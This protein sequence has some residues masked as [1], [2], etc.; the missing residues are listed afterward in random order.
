[1]KKHTLFLFLIGGF[2]SLQSQAQESRS[3]DSINEM[4]STFILK[5]GDN[6]VDSSGDTDPFTSFSDFD[7]MAFSDNY[8]IELEYRFSKW[9]SM[10]V[11]MGNNKWI[12]NKGNIDGVIVNTDQKYLA[13]DLDLKFYY[14]ERFD[15][16]DRNDWVELYL[17]GGLGTV[18][19][20]NTSG[21]SLNFGP[22]ANFW[23]T[24]QFRVNVNS[25]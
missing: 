13:L 24:K 3:N 17:H 20:A 8:N 23:I 18:V 22:G 12:A 10:A 16:F 11:S 21:V 9:F 15:W 7:Q 6:L 4:H 2:L 5:L 1:M 25:T 14:D 19:Q